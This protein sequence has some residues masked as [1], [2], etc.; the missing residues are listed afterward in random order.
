MEEMK[1]LEDYPCG[2]AI[3]IPQPEPPLLKWLWIPILISLLLILFLGHAFA[4]DA[5]LSWDAVTT[6]ADGTPITDLAGYRV[7]FGTSSGIYG[8]PITV[9]V[10]PTPGITISGL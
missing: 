10:S 6:N 1:F 7:Y 2:L 5:I 4:G 8:L 3:E 9:P